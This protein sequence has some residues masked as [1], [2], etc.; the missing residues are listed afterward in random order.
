MSEINIKDVNARLADLE[1][2][3]QKI[4]AETENL[5]NPT[6]KG[7]GKKHSELNQGDA[8]AVIHLHNALIRRVEELTAKVEALEAKVK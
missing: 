6:I 3:T 7:L 2:E 4:K 8:W 5:A 1:R